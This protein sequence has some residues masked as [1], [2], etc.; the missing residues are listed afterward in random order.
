MIDALRPPGPLDPTAGAYKDWLHLNL[1]DHAS[2]GVGLV[3]ASL[4]GDPEDGRSRAVGAALFHLPGA[5]WLGNVE[6]RGL[7]EAGVGMSSI[8]LERVAVAVD[9]LSRSVLASARLREDGL[10]L[11]LTAAPAARPVVVEERLPFGS[12]WISWYAMPRLVLTHASVE[13]AGRRLDLGGASAY[14]DHNWGRWRWGD[15]A[16]WE[17]GAFLAPAPGPWF[18]VSRTTDRTHRHAGPARLEVEVAGRRRSFSGPAVRIAREGTL[19]VRLRRAPGALAAL[20][21]DRRAPRLPARVRV[22]ASDGFDRVEIDFRPR[23]AAQLVAA[24]PGVAGY[25]F[26]H[27]MVGEVSAAGRIAGAD[28][29]CSGLGVFE[30]VD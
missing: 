11:R 16:G 14:H 26:L 27:E 2:G 23:A 21:P 29:S 9:P 15:D 13:A 4:H 6:V 28:A 22:S 10:D 30:Y 3:N 18:V 19:A 24:D 12:G 25:G 7:P 1:F 8:A 20:H 17:W 5:G